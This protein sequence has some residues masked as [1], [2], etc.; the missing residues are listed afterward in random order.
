MAA[1]WIIKACDG[2]KTLD[3]LSDVITVIH[4]EVTDSEGT[5]P[6]IYYGRN[7][8]VVSL[9]KPD[10]KSFIALASITNANLIAWTKA[11]LG[12]DKVTEIETN[13]AAQIAEAKTPTVFSGFVPSS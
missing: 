9:A 7:I 6:N 4:Y 5:A 13:I 2:K 1:T 12:T 3:S 11:A 8:G 10:S